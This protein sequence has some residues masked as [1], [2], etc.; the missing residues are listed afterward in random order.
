MDVLPATGVQEG[1]I[2]PP[3]DHRLALDRLEHLAPV[4]PSEHGEIIGESLRED[5]EV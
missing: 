5:D 2:H 3:I 4:L 1:A